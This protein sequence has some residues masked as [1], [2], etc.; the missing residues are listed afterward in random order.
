[1]RD[2]LKEPLS[3]VIR[4]WMPICPPEFVPLSLH[5]SDTQEFRCFVTNGRLNAISQYISTIY[6]RLLIS[7]APQ[8]RLHLSDYFNNQIKSPLSTLYD[9]YAVDIVLLNPTEGEEEWKFWVI[10]V[11]PFF[12][13]T[14]EGLFESEEGRRILRG[15]SEVEYPVMRVQ[16]FRCVDG[17]EKSLSVAR[18]NVERELGIISI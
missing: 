17:T 6:S 10:E 13:L 2:D 14:G 16:E 15:E 11:N 5:V 4:D 18:R 12:E 1:M 9:R 8:I 7:L 3:F